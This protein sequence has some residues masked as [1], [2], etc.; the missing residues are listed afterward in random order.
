MQWSDPPD[1][2]LPAGSVAELIDFQRVL[3]FPQ[4][5]EEIFAELGLLYKVLRVTT[6]PLCKSITVVG[7]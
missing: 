6:W 3:C 4:V 1:A 7:L 5:Q 2:R